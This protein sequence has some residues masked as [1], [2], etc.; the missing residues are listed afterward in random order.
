[1]KLREAHLTYNFPKSI[2]EKTK[3]IKA[4]HVSLVGTNLALLW[5]HKSNIAH[6]DP[7]STSTGGDDPETTATSRGFNSGVGFESKD[8]Y[9]RQVIC[10]LLQLFYAKQNNSDQI[11]RL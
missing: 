6:I 9:K 5:V 11:E 1:M 7:E 10:S 2:L 3:C 4:A 8:V